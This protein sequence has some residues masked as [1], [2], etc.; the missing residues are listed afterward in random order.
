MKT[1]KQLIAI[2]LAATAIVNAAT[3]QE[4]RQPITI[5]GT[6]YTESESD[7]KETLD[8]NGNPTLTID[9]TTLVEEKVTNQSILKAAKAQ[10]LLTTDKGYGIFLIDGGTI[11]AVKGKEAPVDI[12][13]I[14]TVQYTPRVT[15]SLLK[16]TAK[17]NKDGDVL[18]ET[19]SESHAGFA[20]TEVDFGSNV[21]Q[22]I[23]SFNQT[24]KTVKLA[25]EPFDYI[26]E[27]LSGPITVPAGDDSSEFF[28][29]TVKVGLPIVVAP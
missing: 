22:G 7:H 5:T 14:L 15:G 12:G 16:Y 26:A 28:I 27:S 11:A 25:G 10:G 21:T 6:I 9:S 4:L 24:T 20:E 8:K 17:Y 2:L 1:N 18:S 3:A 13:E 19:T 23:V 29:G